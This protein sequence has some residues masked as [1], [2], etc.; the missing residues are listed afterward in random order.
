MTELANIQ[1]WFTAIITKP[2]A[3]TDKIVMADEH[4]RVDH[5]RLIKP[6]ARLSSQQKIEIYAR[7]Y[8][9]RLL[10]CMEAEYPALRYLLGDD[11]FQTFAR[12]YLVSMPPNS[13]SLYNLSEE[14]PAFLKPSQPQGAQ[15]E[16]FDLPV[17][18]ATVERAVTEVLRIKGLEGNDKHFDT[19][20]A[21]S[22]LFNTDTIKVSPCLRL[23][24]TY[25]P[26]VD[27][28]NAVNNGQEPELPLKKDS[29]VAVCR[30]NYR[31]NIREL[32]LWQW[33]FLN[34][35]QHLG[36]YTSAVNETALQCN[37][38]KS[39]IM[40]DLMLWLPVALGSGYIYYDK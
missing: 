15:D 30:K 35:L 27:L 39:I 40:A 5:T 24:K 8:I 16:N 37:M 2:G 38:D 1:R 26:V 25:F 14:F 29:Y 28:V 21:I 12:A 3:L 11:L 7:G 36:N 23:I 6:S 13:P 18:I 20:Q 9:L 31:V 33:C 32:E 17:S 10:E 4:Y 34:F 22:F 19:A